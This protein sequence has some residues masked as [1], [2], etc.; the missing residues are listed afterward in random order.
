M[1]H[2][3]AAR[4]TMVFGAAAIA[5]LAASAHAVITCK[6]QI[7]DTACGK[8]ALPTN[9]V[10]VPTC[11]Y[12]ALSNPSCPSCSTSQST[13]VM[14]YGPVWTNT[15][16]IGLAIYDPM[17]GSCKWVPESLSFTTASCRGCAGDTCGGPPDPIPE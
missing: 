12:G 11:G 16:V 14:S 7:P 1:S 9:P 2:N 3:H 15:C 6:V 4:R 13:G 8:Y 5:L 10:V 17:T